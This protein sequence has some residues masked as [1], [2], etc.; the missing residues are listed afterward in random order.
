M[1]SNFDEDDRL[2]V[3]LY[4][5]A[6]RDFMDF[7]EMINEDKTSVKCLETLHA[8]CSLK[9]GTARDEKLNELML[10]PIERAM[11]KKRSIANTVS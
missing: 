9:G 11:A 4:A 5:I 10:S 2:A 1:D 7:L 8:M 6:N 3:A